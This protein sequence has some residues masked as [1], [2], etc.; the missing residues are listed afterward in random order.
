VR[1]CQGKLKDALDKPNVHRLIELYAHTI[2]AYGHVKHVTELL[3]E[4]AHQ[5][6]KRAINGSNHHDPKIAAVHSALE[7]DLESRLALELLLNQPESMR[8][9]H[10]IQR[11]HLGREFPS[12]LKEEHLA[13]TDPL[14]EPYLLD[15]LSRLRRKVYSDTSSKTQRILKEELVQKNLRSDPAQHCSYPGYAA[16]GIWFIQNARGRQAPFKWEGRSEDI[17][18][19]LPL[20]NLGK[21]RN[22][23]H[24]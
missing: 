6:L 11:L 22:C 16:G 10:R 8:R 5:T 9:R 23:V 1:L 4:S 14:R 13:C 18:M 17:F 21:C 2:P 3:F 15:R 20:W 7:N 12:W 19:R 24:V